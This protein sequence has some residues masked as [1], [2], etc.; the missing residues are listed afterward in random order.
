[1]TKEKERGFKGIWIPKEIWL[2]KELTIQEKLFLVEID[3][4]DNENGC[5]ASNKYFS[6]FFSLSKGRCSQIINS[7]LKKGFINAKYERSES[8]EIAKRVLKV[9]SGVFK[10]LKGG[11][12]NTKGG[13]LENDKESNTCINNTIEN[14]ISDSS[15]SVPSIKEFLDFANS[16]GIALQ[17]AVECYGRWNRHG[18]KI[19]NDPIENWRGTL[20][21]HF[22]E[23]WPDQV[24]NGTGWSK[25]KEMIKNKDRERDIRELYEQRNFEKIEAFS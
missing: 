17:Y 11:I 19:N 25:E 4:L 2:S 20:R 24:D 10:I 12:K 9:S 3:S 23:Y 8:G 13:Y 18:W 5:Y 22:K 7:L 21:H 1:M 14:R 16:K 15:Q 6:K